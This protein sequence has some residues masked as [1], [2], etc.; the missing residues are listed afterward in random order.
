MA[1]TRIGGLLDLLGR[2]IR[3][4]VRR[5]KK[6]P[7]FTATAVLSLAIGI[8]G[9][10]AI[11]SVVNAV[12]L[13]K[14]PMVAPEE[15]LA[16]FQTDPDFEWSA[17][18]YPDFKDFRER[19]TDVFSGVG[20]T[21][22]VLTQL[23]VGDSQEIIFGEVVS[24]EF[25]SV[26]GIEALVGRTL[27]PSDDVSPGAHPVVMLGYRF[28]KS[29]FGGDPGVVGTEIRLGGRPYTIVGVVP[30][31]Y[32]GFLAAISTS[33]FAP[34]MM[35]NELQPF[36]TDELEERG[37]Q[38]TFVTARLRPGVRLPQ[39]QAA[40]ERAADDMRALH[41]VN[42]DPDAGF[43]VVPK[44][45][46]ILFPPIDVF[47]RAATWLLVVVV[48]LVMVMVVTNLA[49][50]LLART[51]DRRKEIAVR[52]A[53][54][55]R[56]ATI[57]RQ[58][59]LE[60]LLLGLLGGGAGVLFAWLL[61][62]LLLR[63]DTGLPLPV[64]LELDLDGTVLYF[65]F[66]VALGS[67]LL[68]GLFPAL[69]NRSMDVASTIRTE[70]ARGGGGGK[71]RL[72]NAL[73]ISQIAISLFLLLGAGLFTRSLARLESVDPGFG[74]EPAAMLDL[75]IVKESYDED[76][77]RELIRR[78]VDRVGRIPGVA[79]VG[80]TDN[81]HLNPMSTQS[82]AF[83]IDGVEPP[84]GRE[85]HVADRTTVDRGFF[86]ATG[87]RILDG[88]NFDESDRRD[89]ESVAIISEAMAHRFWPDSSAVGRMVR[90]GQA[91]SLRVVGVASDAKV[92]TLGEEPRSFIYVPL[93]QNY[94][95]V[96]TIIARSEI[97]AERTLLDLI[98][99]VN[100][101]DPDLP[102]WNAR[103]MEEHLKTVLIP[104]RLTAG[105][106]TAFAAVALT[107]V[108]IGL[109]GVV[110]YA[111]AQRRRE[112]GIRM[113]L[114]ATAPDV[115]RLLEVGIRMSLGA[116]APDVIRLLMT[117][118]LRLVLIGGI[119]GLGLTILSGRLMSSLLF[120]IGAL[121]PITLAAVILAMLAVTAAATFYPAWS[122]GRVDP[123]KI[124]RA[125]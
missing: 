60:T 30:K 19:T 33:F 18:S 95:S 107:L 25:F 34:V 21:R 40:I 9:G 118:G 69:Q 47:I 92:R 15:L 38:G 51:L 29:R 88:R 123:A 5:L 94:T 96:F 93:E 73:V 22:P 110:G 83:N 62:Q 115:I 27:L 66:T 36:E 61:L 44:D 108:V 97:S 84:P 11:F 58:L 74:E 63:V 26:L 35:V 100:D 37:N 111:A 23:D 46:I 52:L 10:T 12:V 80:L 65:S 14:P 90:R 64:D 39:A 106:L 50:F 17:F 16:V 41:L 113:S 3:Y 54:G 119:I 86:S 89:S 31:G 43:R 122:A 57:S 85:F 99:A 82:T 45:E 81:P 55:A 48:T 53:L 7:G 67:G 121:D 104:A 13:R 71:L 103:T 91:D 105:V 70:D 102:V 6:N 56:R 109:Y 28:W 1:G 72:R 120:Q 68:L 8:G 76:G 42:R 101:V 125:E 49:S 59:L 24:G 4:A 75:A 98:D 114:G 32:P 77:G 87:I 112:V 117:S 2:D 20:S 116:T 78:L 79:A 124:L